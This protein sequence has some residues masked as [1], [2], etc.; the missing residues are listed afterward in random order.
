MSVY[1][2]FTA[3]FN[4][5]KGMYIG[6]SN[7]MDSFNTDLNTL[8]LQT[9]VSGVKIYTVQCLTHL[10]NAFIAHVSP[11]GFGVDYTWSSH[12]TSAYYAWAESAP[13]PV[14]MDAILNAML[15]SSFDNLQQFIGIVDAYRV[16]LWN[17]PFNA[18]FYGALARGFQ[19]WP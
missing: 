11:G 6:I 10:R 12:Y 17:A 1:T 3:A 2:N 13:S 14:T 5:W 19:K 16:A 7:E 8:N 15:S 18:E 9:T 4:N